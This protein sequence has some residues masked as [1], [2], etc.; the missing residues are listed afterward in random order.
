MHAGICHKLTVVRPSA[1]FRILFGGLVFG[2]ALLAQAQTYDISW[3]KIAGGGGSSAGIA[4]DGTVYSVS[5]TVGQL[6]AGNMSGGGYSVAGG[7]WTIIAAVQTEGAP[8]LTITVSNPNVVISWPASATGYALQ[9]NANLNLANN[10]G[11]VSQSTN[12]VNGT[13]YVTVPISSGK[14]VLPLE[15][16]V[17]AS[18]CSCPFEQFLDPDVF[19]P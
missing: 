15:K 16:L 8:A 13:N 5:G 11:A 12:V 2:A 18:S 14:F 10:W 6:D 4:A 19:C 1:T 17:G 9:E 7:F 3:Y